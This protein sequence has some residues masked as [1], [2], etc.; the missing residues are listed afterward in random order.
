MEDPQPRLFI[1][2]PPPLSPQAGADVEK[3]DVSGSRALLHSCAANHLDITR[4]LLCAGANKSQLNNFGHSPESI[5]DLYAFEEL[6]KLL[7]QFPVRGTV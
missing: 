3:A 2:S 6:S 7:L 5:V 1:T 4:L